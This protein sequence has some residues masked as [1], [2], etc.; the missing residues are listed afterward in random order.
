M[1]QINK[2]L[3]RHK[4]WENNNPNSEFVEQTITLNDKLENYSYYEIVSTGY[5]NTIEIVSKCP[6][7]HNATLSVINTWYLGTDN[8]AFRLIGRYV[9]EAVEN[10][11]SF[12]ECVMIEYR[13]NSSETINIH[14]SSL[15]P[16]TIYGIK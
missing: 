12:N 10:K 7:G 9:T 11:I 15:I 3:L 5:N 4:L 2:E 8:Y 16:L 6:V 1:I 14:N 13:P